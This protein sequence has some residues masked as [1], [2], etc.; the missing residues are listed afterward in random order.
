[1]V[2]TALTV[3]VARFDLGPLNNVLMLAIACA[4]ALLVILYF[5]HVRWGTRLTW[6][7]AASGIRLAADPV[8]HHDDRLPDARL[9]CGDASVNFDNSQLPTPE[10]PRRQVFLGIR[11]REL[12]VPRLGR[13]AA[14]LTRVQFRG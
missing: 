14:R 2:G 8:R 11:S 6:V 3:L 7:V 5:M 13:A 1:M 9:G 12:E 10:S 4:K